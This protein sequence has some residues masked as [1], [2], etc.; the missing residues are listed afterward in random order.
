[1][2]RSFVGGLYFIISRSIGPEFGASMGILLALANTISAAMNTIGFCSSLKSLLHT[3]EMDT[4]DG[5]IAFKA[6]GV[7]SIILQ[8][9]LCCI[10][11]DREAEVR[12][13]TPSKS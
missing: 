13:K 6:L 1:M 2:A 8:S 10:G 5:K 11:M 7:V 4:I 12:I 9:L 3:L